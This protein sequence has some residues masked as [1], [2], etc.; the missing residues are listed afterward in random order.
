MNVKE[1]SPFNQIQ[2]IEQAKF[3]YSPLGRAL[4][5]NPRKIS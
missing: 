1:I 4:E 2:I 3:R 5:K